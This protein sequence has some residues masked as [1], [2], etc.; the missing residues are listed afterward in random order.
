MAEVMEG[1]QQQLEEKIADIKR[2]QLENIERR[3]EILRKIEEGNQ[4]TAREEKRRLDQQKKLSKALQ[5]QV[6]IHS[7]MQAHP[8]LFTYT[9]TDTG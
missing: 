3:E 7:A 2:E 9:L 8:S 4:K 1:R 6:Y 5:S